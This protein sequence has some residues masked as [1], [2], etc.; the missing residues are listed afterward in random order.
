MNNKLEAQSR[1][2]EEKF[3]DISVRYLAMEEE[4]ASLKAT[5]TS[6]EDSFNVLNWFKS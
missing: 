3:Q 6:I 5:S 4:L 2:T 1:E